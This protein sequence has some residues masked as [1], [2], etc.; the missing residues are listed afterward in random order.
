VAALQRAQLFCGQIQRTTPVSRGVRIM[1]FRFGSKSNAGRGD[2]AMVCPSCGANLDGESL[3]SVEPARFQPERAEPSPRAMG[4]NDGRGFSLTR[5]SLILALLAVALF[6][7][8]AGFGIGFKVEQS[9][10]KS[11]GK[12]AQAKPKAT[13][14]SAA[15][16]RTQKFRFCLAA[17]GLRWPVIAGKFATQVETPPSGV[18]A[19]VY[20]QALTSC[21]IS[22]RGSPAPPTT[23]AAASNG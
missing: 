16:L 13:T 20:Q 7:G 3:R 10:V 17:K 4:R 12:P 19:A 1:T 11:A 15:Q 5:K 18:T 2:T 23:G 6:G 21:Y 9:T 22:L 14:K 8:G